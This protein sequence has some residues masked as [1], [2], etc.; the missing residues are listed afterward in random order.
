[1]NKLNSSQVGFLKA[2]MSGQDGLIEIG[3]LAKILGKQKGNVIRKLE[4][5]LP[6]DALFKMRSGYLQQG[7]KNSVRENVTYH[8]DPKTAG[9]LVMSYDMMLGIEVLTILQG[10]LA[11]LKKAQGLLLSGQEELALESIT[12]YLD[13]VN[14]SL[15]FSEKDTENE[16]RDKALGQLRRKSFF[17]DTKA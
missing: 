9:A 10:A 14:A 12:S 4:A 7:G 1:M 17:R 6:A 5:Q 13:N 16:T 11:E 3:A 2:S 8:L 15:T